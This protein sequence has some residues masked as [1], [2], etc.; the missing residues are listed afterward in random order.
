M[1]IFWKL[2]LYTNQLDV[3][4]Y[5]RTYSRCCQHD[6]TIHLMTS[7]VD[8]FFILNF[9]KQILNPESVNDVSKFINDV[10]N[11]YEEISGYDSDIDQ[12]FIK[13]KNNWIDYAIILT[14]FIQMMYVMRGDLVLN[15]NDINVDIAKYDCK[16]L[17]LRND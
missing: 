8:M 5:Y 4:S 2:F 14:K 10:Q 16:M 17:S 9:S 1:K 11:K 3:K 6:D 15:N 12:Y 13:I 7:S